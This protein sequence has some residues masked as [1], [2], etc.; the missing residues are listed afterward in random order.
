M[1]LADDLFAGL[2][3]HAKRVTIR[4]R[5]RSILPGPLLFRG[6]SDEQITARVEVTEVIHTTLGA[7]S[8]ADA[9]AD[10]YVDVA[11][12]VRLMRRF[13]PDIHADSPVT[14]LRF[15]LDDALTAEQ[16]ERLAALLPPA[17][18]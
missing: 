5:H 6:A 17:L 14:L 16:A 9:Q 18:L 7:V 10:G 8:E 4:A 15:T 3:Q 13:Y 2:Y 11:E 1:A 12:M